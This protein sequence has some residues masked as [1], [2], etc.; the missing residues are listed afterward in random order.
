MRR[1]SAMPFSLAAIWAR[2]SARLVSGSRE[3]YGGGG[4]QLPGLGLAQP[5][6][7]H[8]QPVVEE[9]ALLVDGAAEGGHG[10]G[11]DAA[12]LGVVAARGDQEAAARCPPSS[13]TGRDD[14]DIGQVGAAV[15]RV[16]DRVH[17][18]R[19]ACAP[20]LRR[21]TSLMDSPI[22]PRW[23]GMCGALAIRLPS[24]SNRAQ[25]KSSR[26]LM[27]TEWAVFSR[28]TPICSAIAMKR[29]LKTSSM[30]G[31]T[32]VPTAVRAGP[33]AYPGQ[34]QVPARRRRRPASR[35]RRRWWR[36]P[37]R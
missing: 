31:S 25:E 19:A 30:T 12:D 3:G 17:V 18:A 5:P 24:A 8:Q 13:N 14:G 15:V 27:L 7:A 32:S 35:G 22:E 11:G 4:E 23:T 20:A 10:A 28:R 16:V 34:Q 37:R 36:R 29:L 26:S 21:S 6:V 2:R 9:H 1:S 33:R